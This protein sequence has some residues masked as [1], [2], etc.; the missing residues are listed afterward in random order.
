LLNYGLLFLKPFDAMD[1]RFPAPN[2]LPGNAPI[3]ELKTPNLVRH[4]AGV[5]LARKIPRRVQGQFRTAVSRLVS[6]TISSIT[7]GSP[8]A[9]AR[10]KASLRLMDRQASSRATK[11]ATSGSGRNETGLGYS[12]LRTGGR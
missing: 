10:L 1:I 5:P 3:R 4:F 9:R 12:R 2:V 6:S 11:R 8:M 7:R